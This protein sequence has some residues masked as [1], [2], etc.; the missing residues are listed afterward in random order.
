MIVVESGM[1]RA[2]EWVTVRRNVAEDYRRAYGEEPDDIV[3][4]GLMIDP[5]DDYSRRRAFYGDITFRSGK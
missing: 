2:G 3:A 5:G 1:Q 4:V